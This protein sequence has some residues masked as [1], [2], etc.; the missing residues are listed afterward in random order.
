MREFPPFLG[1]RDDG[2]ATEDEQGEERVQEGVKVQVKVHLA[3]LCRVCARAY[4]KYVVIRSG[5]ACVVIIYVLS[6]DHLVLM[7]SVE[8]VWCVRRCCGIC[9]LRGDFGIL[10]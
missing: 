6:R 8:S 1:Q 9:G 2:R 7:L 4:C 3:A 10:S 5:P